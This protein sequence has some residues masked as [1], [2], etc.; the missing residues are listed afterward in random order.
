MVQS[1]SRTM[2]GRV[3]ACHNSNHIESKRKICHKRPR[4]WHIRRLAQAISDQGR[5]LHT[6]TR[7]PTQWSQCWNTQ[8]NGV[9]QPTP[10]THQQAEMDPEE[11]REE[12]EYGQTFV[13]LP[14]SFSAVE[15]E[16]RQLEFTIS[17]RLAFF[18][19]QLEC[20]EVKYHTIWKDSLTQVDAATWDERSTICRSRPHMLDR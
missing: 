6:G 11:R 13:Q 17:N 9:A 15:E 1:T 5:I 10:T 2:Q 14:R 4:H 19:S 3:G 8:R 12:D 7:T 20:I 18:T 16:A